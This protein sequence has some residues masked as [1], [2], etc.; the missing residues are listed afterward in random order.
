MNLLELDLH[1]NT[2]SPEATLVLSTRS[3]I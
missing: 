2:P 1:E 3:L